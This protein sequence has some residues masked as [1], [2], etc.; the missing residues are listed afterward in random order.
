M[1]LSEFAG[2]S[3]LKEELRF[4]MD[5]NSLPHAMI[6]EG[7]PGTGK[8]TLAKI[9]AGYFVC[10]SEDGKPCNSC[11]DCIKAESGVHPDII[12]IDGN[13]SAERNIESVRN[14]RSSAYIKPNEAR[15]KVYLLFDCDKMLAPAQN[16]FLKVLE[17]P[18][19]NVA[20]IITVTSASSL[21]QTIRSRA[22]IITLYPPEA[23]EAVSILGEMFSERPYNDL[24]EA[25]E[26][27]SGNIGQAAAML[28]KG[29][30][31]ARKLA[32]EIFSAIPLTSEYQLLKLTSEITSSRDFALSVVEELCEISSE[33]V[34]ASLG[35]ND[36][37]AYTGELIEKLSSKRLLK[38]QEA[39]IRARDVLYN[40]VNLNLYSTWLCSVLRNN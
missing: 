22:R 13:N 21:L 40:N 36:P 1:L 27:C 34:R 4:A 19:E 9:I 26:A 16:A 10:S 31:K 28:E 8:K 18:P 33:C 37:P 11:R 14:I 24:I 32:L 23:G 12:V 38:V 20:F 7:A 2:N 17:E 30:E 25:A 39:L 29:G 6:I 35:V 15:N 5:N 3:E